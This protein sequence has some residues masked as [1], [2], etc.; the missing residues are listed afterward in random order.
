MDYLQAINNKV[1]S[2]VNDIRFE[3]SP[4]DLHFKEMN[5]KSKL[6]TIDWGN[7]L[8]EPPLNTSDVTKKELEFLE[9]L[10][11]YISDRQAQLVMDVDKS[12][13][14]PFH[15][16][17]SDHGLVFPTKL[18]DKCLYQLD[19][20]IL[21][22]KYKYLRPRPFQLAGVYDRVIKVINT[23]S[24]QTPAY[25][26]GHVAQ[27]GMCAAL[28]SWLYPDLSSKFYGAVETVA[29]ARMLQGVHY[30]SDNDAG[31]LISAAIWEDIKYSLNIPH[32]YKEE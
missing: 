13:T 17:I 5:R 18:Y 4:S 26:S 32:E 6:V 12:A 2:G 1:L 16:I 28:L 25:P 24:H 21:K 9:G 20:I 19:P 23:S 30:P 14:F 3:E 22:L 27:A 10:T 11:E 31:M 15:S 29:M 8:S 7:I